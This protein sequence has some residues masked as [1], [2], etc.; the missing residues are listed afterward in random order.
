MK[1]K[2]TA[3][4]AEKTANDF[5]YVT[6]TPVASKSSPSSGRG[7]ERPDPDGDILN[8]DA[9]PEI[10]ADSSGLVLR[11][12]EVAGGIAEIPASNKAAITE[13]L[14][15]VEPSQDPQISSTESLGAPEVSDC[16]PVL[17]AEDESLRCSCGQMME[18]DP[19]MMYS[20]RNCDPYF[21]TPWLVWQD[22]CPNCGRPVWI[23]HDRL[24]CFMCDR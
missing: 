15:A 4:S 16:P 19:D 17:E 8:F 18:L 14:L 7:I 23:D 13:E 9:L 24:P 11:S 1:P 12:P 20:C 6:V 21:D 10:V 2:E 22:P 3:K 5:S